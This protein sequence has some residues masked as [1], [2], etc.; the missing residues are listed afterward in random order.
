MNYLC[1]GRSHFPFG[2]S[3]TR[4]VFHQD[5]LS[6][7]WSFIRMIFSHEGL[8]SGCLPSGWS[9][10]RVVF[11]QGDLLSWGSFIGMVFHQG[12]LS[13]V[14]FFYQDGLPSGWA[15]I[16][17][18]FYEGDL[19]SG[20]SF[21]RV[22]F[23]EGDLSSGWSFIRVVFHQGHS[24]RVV[25]CKGGLASSSFFIRVV[26]HWGGLPFSLPSGWSNI[27]VVFHEGDPSSGGHPSGWSFCLHQDGLSPR[28][29]F[30]EDDPSVVWSSNSIRQVFQQ[31]FCCT[32]YFFCLAV[33]SLTS[34]C[35]LTT[36]H[37]AI[38]CIIALG[39]DGEH[40]CFIVARVHCSSLPL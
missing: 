31:G 25:F 2:W 40:M 3:F 28:W 37:A 4:V 11:H 12:G 32:N 27:R 7:G 38:S 15:F 26:F 30:Y 18:I 10:I 36:V 33:D 22:I 35:G 16:R 21:I 14:F 1:M 19:S 5:G 20:W 34:G 8:S 23:C 17:V 6:S 39:L 9:F 29:F 24:I 13:S